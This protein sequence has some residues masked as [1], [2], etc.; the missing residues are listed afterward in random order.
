M[1]LYVLVISANYSQNHGCYTEHLITLHI[2]LLKWN[3]SGFSY[4]CFF[5]PCI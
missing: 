5:F 4:N 2:N 1:R 3:E